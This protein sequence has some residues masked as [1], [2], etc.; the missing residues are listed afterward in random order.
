MNAQKCRGCGS[1]IELREEGD[2]AT[3]LSCGSSYIKRKER[4]EEVGDHR[5]LECR[6]SETEAI[7]KG[8]G[9]AD[10]ELVYLPFWVF[11]GRFET[12]FTLSRYTE[13]F[14]S[15]T[16]TQ[17]NGSL[18]NDTVISVPACR[19]EMALGLSLP[20]ASSTPLN[21][22]YTLDEGETREFSQESLQTGH[23]FVGAKS[24]ERA[25]T[26]AR[27]FVH[28]RQRLAIEDKFSEL[29]IRFEESEEIRARYLVHRPFW[30]LRGKERTEVVDAHTGE[31][32]TLDKGETVSHIAAFRA[33]RA[34]TLGR[35]AVGFV[36]ACL[37]LGPA[38][39]GTL[40]S[41]GLRLALLIPTSFAMLLFM[42]I[43]IFGLYSPYRLMARHPSI[44]KVGVFN[45]RFSKKGVD[46][47]DLVFWGCTLFLFCPLIGLPL[48]LLASQ[49]YT[50]QATATLLG[51]F[52]QIQ[53][54]IEVSAFLSFVPAI[55]VAGLFISAFKNYIFREGQTANKH[56][57]VTTRWFGIPAL[58]TVAIRGLVTLVIAIPM[59]I[60]AVILDAELVFWPA[61]KAIFG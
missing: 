23:W 52:V 59:L 26:E 22:C 44:R 7:A 14:F 3:C 40:F 54:L 34:Y 31:L 55:L 17:E 46:D 47:P 11:V 13:T 33:N 2:L 1:R 43:F 51:A 6:C 15:V 48:A 32:V 27:R 61:I 30:V 9:G 42:R 5:F 18:D 36:G 60:Y 25:L 58:F 50:G 28:S 8:E 24:Q 35:V 10:V 39:L 37:C 56:S 21:R 20:L 19:T 49:L 57:R 4:L 16:R 53:L 41:E 12:K 45:L 38:L 29:D